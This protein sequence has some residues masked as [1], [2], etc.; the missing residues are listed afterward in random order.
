MASSTGFNVVDTRVI[1]RCIAKR[2]DFVRRYDA[3]SAKYGEVLSK[4]EWQGQ[5]ADAFFNDANIVRT[6]LKGIG[7]ILATM[8]DALLDIRSVYESTDKALAECN[9]NPEEKS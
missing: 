2:A 6:N 9:R 8:C 4:I 1:D 5:G 7:D 3:I